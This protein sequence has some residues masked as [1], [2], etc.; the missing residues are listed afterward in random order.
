MKGLRADSWLWLRR[1]WTQ[2]A[3]HAAPLRGGKAVVGATASI[4][5]GHLAQESGIHDYDDQDKA[6]QG[7]HMA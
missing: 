1:H 7:P 5:L 4:S 2:K 6:S 3:A